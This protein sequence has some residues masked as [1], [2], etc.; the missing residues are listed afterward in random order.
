MAT[1]QH[2]AQNI[3]KPGRALYARVLYDEMWF[4]ARNRLKTSASNLRVNFQRLYYYYYGSRRASRSSNTTS[5][6]YKPDSQAALDDLIGTHTRCVVARTRRTELQQ[7]G[8][9]RRS[10]YWLWDEAC[11]RLLRSKMNIV[12][13]EIDVSNPESDLYEK[14]NDGASLHVKYMDSDDSLY[15]SRGSGWYYFSAMNHYEFSQIQQ[16]IANHYLKSEAQANVTQGKAIWASRKQAIE[17]FSGHPD[18]SNVGALQLRVNDTIWSTTCAPWVRSVARNQSISEISIMIERVGNHEL[19]SILQYKRAANVSYCVHP[20]DFISNG[21][22]QLQQLYNELVL[23]KSD[24]V[25]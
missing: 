16:Y 18:V 9:S 5:V 20:V 15:D 12:M 14:Q 22:L 19:S 8:G 21:V 24:E 23:S 3:S 6:V 1:D 17:L 7:Q 2:W 10:V 4:A 13:I 25:E 11:R